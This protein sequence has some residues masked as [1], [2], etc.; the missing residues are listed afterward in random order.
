MGFVGLSKQKGNLVL[1][2][3]KNSTYFT[4]DRVK[5]NETILKESNKLST[6]TLPYS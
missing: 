2:R 6:K 4:I 5:K 3:Y 1:Q